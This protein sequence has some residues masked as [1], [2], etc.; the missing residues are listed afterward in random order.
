VALST[1]EA[2]YMCLR[3]QAHRDTIPLTRLLEEVKNRLDLHVVSIPSIP[4][5]LFEDN[6]GVLPKCDP[7]RNINN[8]YHHFR[9]HVCRKLIHIEH[10]NT[11]NQVAD[12]FTKPLPL[13][14]FLKHWKALQLW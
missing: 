10:V 4:C 5:T 12:M 8:K 7:I 13:L 6:S 9:D 2:E 3:S 11:A 1:T 14:A